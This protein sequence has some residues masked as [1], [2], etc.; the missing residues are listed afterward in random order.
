MVFPVLFVMAS[1]VTIDGGCVHFIME[2][3]DLWLEIA[4]QAM[5]ASR[6]Y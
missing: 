2:F 1:L 3:Y 6:G 4:G 5:P